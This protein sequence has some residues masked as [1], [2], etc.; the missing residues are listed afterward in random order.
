MVK[1]AAAIMVALSTGVVAQDAFLEQ[2]TGESIPTP[3]LDRIEY[4]SANPIR[5]DTATAEQLV[6]LPFM[7]RS[8]ARRIVQTMRTQ[9]PNTITELCNAVACS[10]E[11]RIVLERCTRIGGSLSISLPISI[12]TRAMIWATPPR[13][14]YDGRMRGT[15][16]E[17]YTRTIATTGTTSISALSNKDA[18]EPLLADFTSLSVRI[19]IGGTR[20]VLGDYTTEWGLGLIAWRPF[21]ARKGTDVIGP[22]TET[23]RGIGQYRSALEYRFFRGIA[24][25]RPLQIS[26]S[27]AVVCRAG[28]SLLPRSASIDTV[29]GTILSLATDG[30]HRTATELA[31]RH[32]STERAA[33]GTLEYRSGPMILGAGIIA[34]DYPMPITSSSTL[35]MPAQ[36]GMFSSLFAVYTE[37]PTT[38]AAE[39]ARDYA[40]NIAA[41]LGAEYRFNRTIVALGLRWYAPH[42]RA[43]FGYNFGESSQ[44][45]NES[46]TY[47]GIRSRI[48]RNVQYLGYADIYRHIEPI[49]VLPRLRRGSDLFN[50]LRIRLDKG[51]TVFVRVRQEHR[52]EDLSTDTGT[53]AEEILRTTLR[54]EV[55]YTTNAGAYVRFRAE[56]V[57]RIPTDAAI[58]RAE[59]GIAAFGEL[60]IPIGQQATF[61]GRVTMYRT[62]SFNSAVYTFEQLAPGFL[63]S[64]PLY[65]A[66]S[67]WFVFVRLEPL[68]RIALWLRYGST[69]RLDTR[70][71]GSSIT[72]IDGNRDAR[73][74]VQLDVRL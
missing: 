38:I 37:E 5:L 46:G 54:C 59:H 14:A 2:I 53:A 67:R 52:T 4:F 10:D 23:G 43:P 51:T 24:L 29:A 1:V 74:Y 69:E 44:P 55:Q 49:G 3:D 42:Y 30:Y 62:E 58:Q 21:G 61:G 31:R 17:L 15:A 11:Q 71:L 36:R 26:D 64:V 65:G 73:L 45:T 13:A 40:G 63:V 20:A 72:E 60:S 32:N 25:E 35:V 7:T 28:Y 39:L 18:G 22:C 33:F 47:I 9:K 6:Q 50:E 8:T 70:T 68:E 48:G 41:R 57:W 16:H 19:D 56:G 66:G 34:L 27:T 12:R